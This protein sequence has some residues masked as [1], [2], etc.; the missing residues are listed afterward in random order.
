MTDRNFTVAAARAARRKEEESPAE[1]WFREHETAPP[2]VPT[3]RQLAYA[4]ANPGAAVAW[5]ARTLPRRR[6][7]APLT[8]RNAVAAVGRR[9]PA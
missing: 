4:A 5:I 2:S 3:S 7:C 8:R 6:R 9:V 1:R